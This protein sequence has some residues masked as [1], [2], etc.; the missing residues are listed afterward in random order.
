M[1]ELDRTTEAIVL[2]NERWRKLNANMRQC[3][4]FRANMCQHCSLSAVQRKTGFLE[5]S[6]WPE[7]DMFGS[8]PWFLFPGH[9]LPPRLTPTNC[10]KVYSLNLIDQF[11]TCF[12]RR[13]LLQ[14]CLGKAFP[15]KHAF[16][17]VAQC[18][19]FALFGCIPLFAWTR[20]NFIAG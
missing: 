3:V 13:W 19:P 9:K 16:V 5:Q 8:M 7:F 10:Y 14:V 12:R 11:T 15:Q 6:W 20:L 2:M 18:C 4:P 17:L 1:K